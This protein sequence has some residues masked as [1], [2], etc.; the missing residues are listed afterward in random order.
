MIT[1]V[2]QTPIPLDPVRQQI[3]PTPPI[4]PPA[5]PRPADQPLQA[6][7]STKDKFNPN[8]N[9]DRNRRDQALEDQQRVETA[10]KLRS[11]YLRLKDLKR[12][13]GA[14][15]DS[16]NASLAKEI[17][18]EAA[19]VAATIPVNVGI[20]A[21]DAQEAA[22]VAQQTATKAETTDDAAMNVP[23]ALDIARAGLG[24]AKDVVEIAAEVPHHP[25]ADRIAINEMRQQVLGAMADV[26]AI[27]GNVAAD[28]PQ[29]A[30]PS[31]DHIDMQ[32]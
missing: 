10:N 16:G 32:A 19:T 4:D 13:A 11:A 27:A 2:L 18:G 23:A 5:P 9:D 14:A 15:A 22:R 25:V 31:A 8:T 6:S 26:E 17:A 24:S 29:V 21:L 7:E 3:T 12:E 30:S 1:P 28:T 20:I